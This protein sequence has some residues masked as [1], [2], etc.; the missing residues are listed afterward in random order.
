MKPFTSILKTAALTAFA[1]VAT[2]VTTTAQP[3]FEKPTSREV[4]ESLDVRRGQYLDR[5]REM[6]DHRIGLYRAENFT[7]IDNSAM[8]I[9]LMRGEEIEACNNRVLELMQEP[10]TGPFWMFPTTMVAYAG[11]DKLSTEAQ[12]AIRE[13]WRTTRQLRGDTENH[14]VMYHTCLLYTSDAADE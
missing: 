11:R 7:K 6:Q 12:E 4:V 9:L 13:A 5:V 8:A 2:G 14:W 3:S 1:L 10:G